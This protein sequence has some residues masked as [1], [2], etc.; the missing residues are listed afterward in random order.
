M[1]QLFGSVA[2][3]SQMGKSKVIK[4]NTKEVYLLISQAK[5]SNNVGIY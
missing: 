4:M 5:L 2:P 1:Q 3:A